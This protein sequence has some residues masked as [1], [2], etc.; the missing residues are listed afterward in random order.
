MAKRY[1]HKAYTDNAIP[2]LVGLSVHHTFLQ[3]PWYDQLV[4][5]VCL[6]VPDNPIHEQPIQVRVM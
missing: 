1:L 2:Y 5:R 4:K 6:L 3:S